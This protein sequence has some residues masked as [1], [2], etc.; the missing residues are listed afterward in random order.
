MQFNS[1]YNWLNIA[2]RIIQNH[3]DRTHT[4]HSLFAHKFKR[5]VPCVC[6]TTNSTTNTIAPNVDIKSTK[7]IKLKTKRANV[8][9]N[10]RMKKK[11]KVNFNAN[12]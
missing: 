7:Y 8:C 10:L 4:V 11:N 12:G 6:A 1:L 2:N 5:T 9:T 3:F